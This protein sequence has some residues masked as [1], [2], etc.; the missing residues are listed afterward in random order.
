VGTSSATSG[1]TLA[2]PWVT[3]DS[4]GHMTNKGT[5]T[6]TISGFVPTAPSSTAVDAAAQA[7]SIVIGKA[8]ASSANIPAAYA[9]LYINMPWSSDWATQFLINSQ[10]NAY[11]RMANNT[12]TNSTTTTTGTWKRIAPANA[13]GIVQIANGGTGASALTG[14]LGSN[15]SAFYANYTGSVVADCNSATTGGL[16]R[17]NSSSTKTNAPASGT[18]TGILIVF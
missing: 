7:N 8:A 5:H 11:F 3:F 12:T 14:L 13:D 10:G 9:S 2:V 6:H 17:V 16:Y 18:Y 4:C 15:G 1:S